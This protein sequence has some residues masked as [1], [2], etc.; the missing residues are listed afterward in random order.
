MEEGVRDLKGDNYRS[1]QAFLI[2][3]LLQIEEVVL[4]AE[5]V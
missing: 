5:A 1:Q 4:V 3:D 2:E